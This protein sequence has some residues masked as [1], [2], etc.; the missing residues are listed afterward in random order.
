MVKTTSFN[1]VPVAQSMPA[2]FGF[3]VPTRKA[4]LFSHQ[5]G[6]VC[7][8]D[9]RMRGEFMDISLT[10]VEERTLNKMFSKIDISA[11]EH[12]HFGKVVTRIVSYLKLPVQLLRNRVGEE[13]SENVD[14]AVK[15]LFLAEFGGSTDVS[16]EAWQWCHVI[17]GDFTRCPK[18]KEHVGEYVLL[19]YPN[20]D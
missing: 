18:L 16:H 19:I 2:N 11:P 4:P 17:D 13:L 5:T 20:S 6:G 12:L 10:P 15:E 1:I 14:E 9:S 7:C 8:I 3:L